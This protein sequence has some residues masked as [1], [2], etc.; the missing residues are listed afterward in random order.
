MLRHMY[1]DLYVS[2]LQIHISISFRTELCLSAKIGTC[3]CTTLKGD[4]QVSS[5]SINSLCVC[6]W[7]NCINCFFFEHR[8]IRQKNKEKLK[9]RRI[10]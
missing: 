10:C 2:E 1:I 7:P 6:V 3:I 8:Y 5:V 9:K 4:V